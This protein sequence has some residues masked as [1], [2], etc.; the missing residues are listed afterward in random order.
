M[1]F[2]RT[3]IKHAEKILSCEIIRLSFEYRY[4]FASSVPS[5]EDLIH[6]YYENNGENY[7]LILVEH[8]IGA[9]KSFKTRNDFLRVDPHT[10]AVFSR[11]WEPSFKR[12]K[13][14]QVIL[15][16]KLKHGNRGWKFTGLS[17]NYIKELF[18]NAD[19]L[20]SII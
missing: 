13:L 15:E 6:G 3:S 18:D 14:L 8:T 17:Y 10:V 19:N 12:Q 5:E 1:N 7:N 9:S 20:A 16:S 4:M 2:S 11:A